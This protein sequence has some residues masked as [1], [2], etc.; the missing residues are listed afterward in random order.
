MAD[1]NSDLKPLLQS[2][3]D[4][5]EQLAALQHRIDLLEGD[6]G[7]SHNKAAGNPS[8][9]DANKFRAIRICYV[10]AE[11][12]YRHCNG[13][14]VDWVKRSREWLFGRHVSE[15]LGDAAF[16]IKEKYFTGALADETVTYEEKIYTPM[17]VC[18]IFRRSTF[19]ILMMPAIYRAFLFPSPTPAVFVEAEKALEA[20]KTT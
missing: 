8:Q 5:L 12:R 15:I 9:R 7:T 6:T 16:N 18:N 3:A 1:E 20:E 14:Y 17:G 11:L 10:D 19:P 13:P 2:K 4:L